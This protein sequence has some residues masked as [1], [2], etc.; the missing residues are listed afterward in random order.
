MPAL[1]ARSP[2]VAMLGRPPPLMQL[3]THALTPR[4]RAAAIGLVR[5]VSPRRPANPTPRVAAPW[6]YTFL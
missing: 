1:R 5:D 6:H 2:P 4:S 3:D